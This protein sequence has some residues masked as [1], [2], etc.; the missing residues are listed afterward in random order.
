M[1][2]KAKQSRPLTV[3]VL[4]Q[5]RA[6]FPI[7]EEWIARMCAEFARCGY[8]I[9][10]DDLRTI[11]RKDGFIFYLSHTSVTQRIRWTDATLKEAF[12]QFFQIPQDEDED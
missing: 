1:P 9:C 2:K 4:R 12:G 7:N 8:Q 5:E 6:D 11:A 3:L 10:A